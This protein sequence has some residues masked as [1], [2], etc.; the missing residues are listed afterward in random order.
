MSEYQQHASVVFILRHMP[1]GSERQIPVAED[2]WEYQEYLTWEAIPGNDID[3][4]DPVPPPTL[5]ERRAA[6]A[7]IMEQR[8]RQEAT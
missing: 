4:A 7:R 2:N 1:D 6:K 5:A 8:A 3:P